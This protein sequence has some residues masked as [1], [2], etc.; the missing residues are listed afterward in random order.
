MEKLENSDRI[1][2][3]G[4]LST[5]EAESIHDAT[6]YFICERRIHRLFENGPKGI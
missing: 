6:A 3:A 5:D 2:I 1:H 4:I